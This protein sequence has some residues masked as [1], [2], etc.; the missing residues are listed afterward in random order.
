VSAGIAI[1]R[2]RRTRAASCIV[3]RRC[4]GKTSTALTFVKLLV[5]GATVDVQAAPPSRVGV[6]FVPRDG[7]DPR[8][9]PGR[10]CAADNGAFSG[11]DA[12]SFVEMLERL[13]GFPMQFV[14]APDVVANAGETLRLFRLWE[15][16][17]HALGFPVAFVAQDGITVDALPWGSCEAVFIGGTTQFKLSSE[18]DTILAYAAARGKHRHVGRVNSWPRVQH[19]WGLTDTIDGSG[20]SKW[21]KRIKMFIA[22]ADRLEGKPHR[23]SMQLG[24]KV[25]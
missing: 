1:V 14:T 3:E 13:S 8:N 22:W 21:P 6:L 24:L 15:P 19:F 18:A 10:V 16:M 9:V 5:S 20:F 23:T 2:Q 7:N 12:R 11:L 25:A 4:I 17:I